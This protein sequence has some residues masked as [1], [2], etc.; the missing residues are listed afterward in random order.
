V[1]VPEFEKSMFEALLARRSVRK[2]KPRKVEAQTINNLLEAAVRAPTALGQE[3]WAFVIIQDKILL[4]NLSDYAKPLFLNQIHQHHQHHQHHSKQAQHKLDLFN[5]PDFNIFHDA[6]TLIVICGEKNAPFFTADC[7]LAAENMMLAA[8]AMNL[9]SCVI[10]SALS[11]FEVPEVRTKLRIP[12]SY[13]A[14]APIVIG[15]P[16]EKNIPSSRKS[17]IVFSCI[18]AP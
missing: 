4:K 9:G 6:N 8:C 10:G 16:D 15:Y 11:A 5:R 2:Y 12:D 14:V 13:S 7:W 3:P 18:S 17:P 1:P